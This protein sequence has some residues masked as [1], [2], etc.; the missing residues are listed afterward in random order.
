MMLPNPTSPVEVPLDSRAQLRQLMALLGIGPTI[1]GAW[2]GLARK[3]V[4]REYLYY[5]RIPT[6]VIKTLEHMLNIV[7]TLRQT[8]SQE[9]GAT[10]CG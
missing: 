6:H 2:V 1:V 4:E 10:N 8:E 3:D 7:T 5:G 9:R